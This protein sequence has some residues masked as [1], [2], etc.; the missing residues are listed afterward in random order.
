MYR[1][2]DRQVT[3]LAPGNQI[4]LWSMRSWV[5]AV[6]NGRCTCAALG[7]AFARWRL[8]D[9]LGDFNMAMFLLNVEGQGGLRFAP[10]QCGLVRDD[11][12]MLLA[13][14]HAGAVGDGTMLQRFAA[15]LVQPD[16]E[17]PFLTAVHA[18][19]DVL[20]RTPVARDHD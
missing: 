12:A 18:A 1:F 2:L 16:A 3:D 19:A 5:A 11:E 20:R 15:Q 4:L 6:A 13:M 8:A 17:G 7:P 10:P 14:F 9:L